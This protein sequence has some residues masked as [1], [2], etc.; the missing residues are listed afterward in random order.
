MKHRLTGFA[1]RLWLIKMRPDQ[2]QAKRDR[3]SIM[4]HARHAIMQGPRDLKR[5]GLSNREGRDNRR[6]RK[7]RRDN[8][9]RVLFSCPAFEIIL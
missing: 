5:R 6:M 7:H 4:N 1:V 2:R 3:G 8:P 9:V